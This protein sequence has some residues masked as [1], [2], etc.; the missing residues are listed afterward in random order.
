MIHVQTFPL[1]PLQ[2][3]CFLVYKDK[4][5]LAIDPG[6]DPSPLVQYVRKNDLTL[7]LILNTHFHV[8]HILGNK[9]LKDATGAPILANPEDDYLLQTQVGRGG[10]MIGLPEL[11]D[12]DYE[13]LHPGRT[14]FLGES[15][16]VLATPGHTPG[17]LSFYFPDSGKVFS[18]D[19][20]F[21]RSVGRTDFPGGS[22]DTLIKA[23]Q[24]N[25]FTLPEDTVIYC[26]HG[27]ETTVREEKQSNPFFRGGFFM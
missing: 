23:V 12:F 3:N 27:P 6:G 22:T 24:E 16:D 20:I 9:Q 7:R 5:A 15:C 14:E 2:T 1:G 25:I 10:A 13:P 17:S 18:G 21:S 11:E 26:G 4:E 8:D 19:L